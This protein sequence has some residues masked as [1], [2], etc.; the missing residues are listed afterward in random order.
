V[1]AR[2]RIRGAIW[3]SCRRSMGRRRSQEHLTSQPILG[4]HTK[5]G[6]FQPPSITCPGSSLPGGSSTIIE[7]PMCRT[8]Q[9]PEVLRRL[10]AIRVRMAHWYQAGPRTSVNTRT[11]SR[12]PCSSNSNAGNRGWR[13][14]KLVVLVV[15]D[16]PQILRVMRASLS[17]SGHEVVTAWNG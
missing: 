17:A 1:A 6:I 3:C 4:T 5:P 8:S 14:S 7:Q 13:M 15:D 11:D 16:E 9:A 12:S 10:V 2:S